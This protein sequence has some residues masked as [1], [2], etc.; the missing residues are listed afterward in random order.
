VPKLLLVVRPRRLRAGRAVG[1]SGTVTPAEAALVVCVVERRVGRRWVRVQ[2][3]RI[4]VRRGRFRTRIRE[5]RA[6]LYR[7][8]IVAPNATI[9]RLVRFKH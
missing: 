3:K 5:R 1:V 8:S 7:V 6:G 2:R 4:A 9:R